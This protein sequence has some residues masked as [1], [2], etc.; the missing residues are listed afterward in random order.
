MCEESAS[1]DLTPHDVASG[2]D[3]ISQVLEEQTRAAQQGELSLAFGVDSTSAEDRRG[4]GKGAGGT[5]EP[6]A[7]ESW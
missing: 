7:R 3:A 5:G 2:L 1:F 4:E 6:Y